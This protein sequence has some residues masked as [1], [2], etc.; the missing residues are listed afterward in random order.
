MYLPEAICIM[1]LALWLLELSL[2]F[3]F[4][5]GGGSGVVHYSQEVMDIHPA[6]PKKTAKTEK[7]PGKWNLKSCG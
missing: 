5:H 4:G 3:D 2:S 1:N 7:A 6:M